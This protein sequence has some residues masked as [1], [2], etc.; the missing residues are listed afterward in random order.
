MPCERADGRI[1]ISTGPLRATLESHGA[2]CDW[3]LRPPWTRDTWLGV[4]VPW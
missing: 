3:L 1:A 2:C 4:G